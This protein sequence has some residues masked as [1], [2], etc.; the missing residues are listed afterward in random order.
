[1]THEYYM[2]QALDL[3]REA[4]EEGEVPVGC[5]IVWD[6]GRIVGRG[7]N[8]RETGR[9]PWP[10]PSWRPSGR[11]TP[12]WE[13]GGCT[14]LPLYVTLEPCPMCAGGIINAR[15]PQAMATGQKTRR[16]GAAARCSTSL[17]SH[18]TT[19]PGSTAAFWRRNVRPAPGFFP[20]SA[21]QASGRPALCL[22]LL[23]ELY[24]KSK[25]I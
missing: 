22:R 6:D 20:A 5:V 8:R 23:F 25:K 1:M 13:G 11:P 18:S 7:R 4:M 14:R 12:S 21:G 19:T 9:M 3:A 15:I 16:P 10:M 17:R 24:I 2:R